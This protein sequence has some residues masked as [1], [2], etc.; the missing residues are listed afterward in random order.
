MGFPTN[1]LQNECFVGRGTAI[2]LRGLSI[3]LAEDLSELPMLRDGPLAEREG[4]ERKVSLSLS[5]ERAYAPFRQISYRK[6]FFS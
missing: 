2:Y 6:N 4:L 5:V 1:H 3:R